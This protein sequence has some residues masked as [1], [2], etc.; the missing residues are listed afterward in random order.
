MK[1]HE[2]QGKDIL[3][4]FDVP[5]PSGHVAFTPDE[6]VDAAR[7]LG[8]SVWVVKS[9]IHAG[10]RGKGD[11]FDPSTRELVLNG[12]VKVAKSL[13]EVRDYASKM[14][15]NLL[16]TIQTGAEG[17]IVRRVLVEEGIGI[18]KELYA[19]M[20]L[21]RAQSRNVMM[22][23]TEG[24]TEIEKVAAE[25][26]DK[27]IRVAIDPATG[28]QAFHARQLAFGLGLN[29]NAFKN[30]VKFLTALPR[31]Y[32]ALDASLFEINPLVITTDGRV[33]AL[34]AKVTLDDNALDRHPEFAALRDL[35]EE[36]PLEIEASK[37]N[38][39][40][41]NHHISSGETGRVL[42]YDKPHYGDHR[43]YF[44]VVEPVEFVSFEDTEARF[45][46]DWIALKDSK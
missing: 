33:L 32:D 30:A 22:V 24:G 11:L 12:G 28:F 45:E 9:Q 38:L 23:S 17:K 41:I 4:T 36:A 31:A 16:V 40:Y 39:N 46:Q 37:Y 18:E 15:G 3:R 19:G 13:E 8:G 26:P 14:L 10:G 5:T 6:A 21:D 34:D 2:Y 43:H 20:L 7:K 29:G 25:T 35:D 44:G 27:I 1:I 42:A